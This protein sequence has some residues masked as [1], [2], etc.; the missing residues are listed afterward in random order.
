MRFEAI[1]TIAAL[2]LFSV[3]AGMAQQPDFPRFEVASIKPS[4]GQ[5][6]ETNYLPAEPFV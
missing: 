4:S 6:G 1:L 5:G 3:V 2:S